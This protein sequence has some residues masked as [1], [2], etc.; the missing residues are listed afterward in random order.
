MQDKIVEGRYVIEEVPC[1]CTHEREVQYFEY[2]PRRG[3]CM[4]CYGIV[5]LDKADIIKR[6]D[7]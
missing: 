5:D 3:L 4:I 7:D 1:A 6:H 2:E